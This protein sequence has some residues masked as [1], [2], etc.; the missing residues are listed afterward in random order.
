MK[1][2]LMKTVKISAVILSA[3]TVF[4]C[5]VPVTSSAW[6]RVG[7]DVNANDMAEVL[8]EYYGVKYKEWEIYGYDDW[9]D[10]VQMRLFREDVDL[11][12]V[13]DVYGGAGGI[14]VKYYGTHIYMTTENKAEVEAFIK[15]N[16]PEYIISDEEEYDENGY[17]FKIV[18]YDHDKSLTD[19]PEICS[20]LKEKDL[21]SAFDYYINDYS[22]SGMSFATNSYLTGYETNFSTEKQDELVQ[23]LS[24]FVERNNLDF[25]VVSFDTLKMRTFGDGVNV[26]FY[27]MPSYVDAEGNYPYY[28]AVPTVCA[29]P[30]EGVSDYEHGMVARKISEELGLPSGILT[31]QST[32]RE[33][34]SSDEHIDVFNAVLGDANNDGKMSISDAVAVLQ[35]LANSEKYPLSAQGKYNADCDGSDGITGLD[36]AAIQKFDAG[37]IDK[38]PETPN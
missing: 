27:E 2:K 5:S 33:I 35:N 34:S 18:T 14:A 21:I 23:K 31:D 17:N 7:S 22:F 3:L 4:P 37:I 20:A 6:G 1:F 13:S 9:I 12:L 30:N 26:P 19:I 15:E 36:A 24:D 8:S 11:D 38:L 29:I 32:G 25:S 10:G 16:Y 28:F